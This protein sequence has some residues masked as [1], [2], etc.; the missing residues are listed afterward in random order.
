MPH[1]LPAIVVNNLSGVPPW[2]WVNGCRISRGCSGQGGRFPH[3]W[4]LALRFLACRI[5]GSVDTP[6]LRGIPLPLLVFLLLIGIAGLPHPL[7]GGWRLPSPKAVSDFPCIADSCGGVR[8]MGVSTVKHRVHWLPQSGEQHVHIHLNGL[9]YG[10]NLRYGPRAGGEYDVC[11]N[12]GSR[13]CPG[14]LFVLS[15]F[16][17]QFP[18]Q[19]V[20]VPAATGVDGGLPLLDAPI[21]KGIGDGVGYGVKPRLS[22]CLEI[23]V[24]DMRGLMVD[25]STGKAQQIRFAVQ[26][27]RWQVNDP[28]VGF[29]LTSS[30]AYLHAVVAAQHGGQ[31]GK[32]ADNVP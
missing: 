23:A 25:E 29:G 21:L 15:V 7:L 22:Q 13:V 20:E 10:V 14:L 3:I 30:Y 5:L 26:G 31:Q 18:C 16:Q 4:S 9:Q 19:P 2:L 6:A 17:T 8:A 12:A 1:R 11:Q 32:T 24:A 27:Q 28:P